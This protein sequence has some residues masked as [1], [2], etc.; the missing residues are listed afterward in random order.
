MQ[1]LG[2]WFKLGLISFGGPAGQIA[3]MHQE[4]V[5]RRQWISDQQFLR[6]LNF[7]MLLPGPEAQQLATYMGW[8]LHGIPGG[9]VAGSLFVL[10]AVFVLLLLSWLSVAYAEVP[11]IAGLFYGIKAVVLAIVLEALIRISQRALSHPL[12]WLF[13]LGALAGIQLPFFSFPLIIAA[14]AL[15]GLGLYYW[16]PDIFQHK[17]ADAQDEAA[18]AAASREALPSLRRNLTLVGVFVLLWIIPVALVWAW[19]GSDDV[20][21][22]EAIFFTEAAF[23]TFGGAYA[24]LTY[25]ADVAVNSYGWLTTDQMIQGLGLAEST[26]GPLIMVT[27]YVGFVGAWNFSGPFAPL[28]YG[29]LGALLTTYVTFLPCFLFIFLGAPYIEFLARQ[30]KLQAALTGVTAA[31]VG[32]IANLALFFGSN[33]L[34]PDGGFDWAALVLAVIAFLLLRFLRLQIYWVVPLGAVAGMLWTLALGS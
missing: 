27:Q 4:L 10:P 19:R 33:V 26:P 7:C 9:V 12:L 17:D 30:E 3:I 23:I 29:T 32:V 24:V 6:A 21:V 31:V 28:L 15:A 14:A 25:I 16:R 34:F 22:Q 13:A 18:S 2:F 11:A 8:R 20:L 5:E 1:A